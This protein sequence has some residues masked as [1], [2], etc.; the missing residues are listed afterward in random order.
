M[1]SSGACLTREATEMALSR[2]LSVSEAAEMPPV[3][4]PKMVRGSMPLD[5]FLFAL[6]EEKRRRRQS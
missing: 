5:K 3:T 2:T 6:N 1:A 4:A